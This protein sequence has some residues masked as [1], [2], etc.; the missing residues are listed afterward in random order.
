[1]N[2]PADGGVVWRLARFGELAGT[3]VYD[4]LAL[5]QR[6][7]LIEQGIPALDADGLDAQARHLCGRDGGRLVAYSRLFEPKETGAPLR[8]GRVVVSAEA[9]GQG[10]G[11]D[12]MR[13]ALRCAD[14]LAA[15][16]EVLVSAQAHLKDFYAGL[17][18]E[19]RS[20]VYDDHGV[21]HIDMVRPASRA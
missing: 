4:I 2:A 18:F 10:L 12:L 16:A 8:I 14:T 15:G 6:V 9:R 21:P 19:V 11:R 5:R 1:M 17:G 3:D 20:A 7:F 13:E